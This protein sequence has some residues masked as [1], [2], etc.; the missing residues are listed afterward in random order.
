MTLPAALQAVWLGLEGIAC[1]SLRLGPGQYRAALEVGG[2][3]FGLL[4]EEEQES[5]LAGYFHWLKSLSYPVQFLVRVLPLDLQ[6]YLDALDE[7]ARRQPSPALAA[8]TRDHMTFLQGLARGRS[9]LERHL[10][11]IVPAGD[12]EERPRWPFGKPFEPLDAGSAR[13][14]LTARCDD[15]TRGLGRCRLSVRRLSSLDLAQLLYACWCPERARLQRL[16]AELVEYA[17]LTV[18]GRRHPERRS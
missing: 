9:L 1:D 14:Q 4:G 5:L 13:R 7:R 16:R 3:S 17:A 15:A 6:G 18:R 8:L 11:V 10:Y 2:L 12:G